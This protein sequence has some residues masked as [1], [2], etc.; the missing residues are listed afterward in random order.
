MFRC[1]FVIRLFTVFIFVHAMCDALQAKTI[2]SIDSQKAFDNI[3]EKLIK[4]LN[5]GE[6]DIVIVFTTS[7]LVAKDEHII[8]QGIKA[9]FL[10]L[11]IKGKSTIIIPEGDL[12]KNG[13]LYRN[14]F[15]VS[16]CWSL[17]GKLVD[18]W[19]KIKYGSSL[20]EIVDK[21]RGLCRIK[22]EDPIADQSNPEFAYI[23]IPHWF[24]SSTY[25]ITEIKN[26]Y[27]Y[28]IA[29]DIEISYNKGYNVND[30]YNLWK[31][32]IR[33]KLCN[34]EG[35]RAFPSIYDGQMHLPSGVTI[36]RE[37][38]MNNFLSIIDCTFSSVEVS[39]LKFLGNS[40]SNSKPLIEVS[41]VIA[42]SIRIRKCEFQGMKSRVIS[43]S[44]TDNVRID[45]NSFSDCYITCILS[46]NESNRTIVNN[47][48]F[49]NMGKGLKNSFCV[50][51][52]GCDYHIYN[53]KMIDFGYGGIGVGV[54]YKSSQA[55]PSRGFVEKN[56]LY[57]TEGY[58]NDIDNNCIMDGGAI[59]VW[60]KNDG[61]I[62][63]NNYIHGFSGKGGNRGIFCDDGAYNVQIYGNVISGIMNSYCI[64]SRRV[65]YVEKTQTAESG[66]ERSNINVVIRDN[67]VDGPI[68]FVG[69]E[70]QENGCVSGTNYFLV[71]END[72]HF[73][74]TFE[75]VQKSSDVLL[76]YYGGKDGREALSTQS[77]RVL[78]KAKL[79]R[80]MHNYLKRGR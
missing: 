73:D 11:Q 34:I 60:T 39:G 6:N 16:N 46:D 38:Q 65:S 77:C 36:A 72:K 17:D 13:D 68:L 70:T 24:R 44:S 27:I 51:C 58:L 48:T 54:W 30:D 50:I 4:T 22:S 26:Q 55:R 59:Y 8:L 33:Y 52:R 67:I 3:Q 75:N 80:S 57:F 61:A 35:Q 12:Y 66:I 41:D 69:N 37:G 21:P 29:P 18:F 23:L 2:I 63:R 45:N 79:W 10:R 40:N 5:S 14:S 28:F 71:K 43:I 47:N 64:E 1:R 53:N 62:I 78:K 7:T 31:L 76:D 32:K 42:E 74:N 19:T 49:T 9:P 20:V 15:D 25:I 56:E